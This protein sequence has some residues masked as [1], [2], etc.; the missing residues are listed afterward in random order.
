LEAAPT[1]ISGVFLT[2]YHIGT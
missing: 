2:A 1:L